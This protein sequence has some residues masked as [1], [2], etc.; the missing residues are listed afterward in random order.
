MIKDDPDEYIR[1]NLDT[2]AVFGF[3]ESTTPAMSVSDD[4]RKRLYQRAWDR[5]NGFAFMLETFSDII[6][7]KEANDT[8]TDFVRAKIRH[9]VKDQRVADLLCPSD[10]YAKRPLATDHYY[11]TYNRSNVN[12]ID[13]KANP[14]QEITERGIRTAAG[15]IDLDIII[16]ATGFDAVTGNYLKIETVGRD[17]V[18]LQDKWAGGPSAFA[19]VA[20][21]GFP[22]L[23][24]IYGPFCP[25]TSQPLVHEW[26]VNWFA[27]LI[28]HARGSGR[29]TVDVDASTE[30]AWVQTCREGAQQTLFAQTDSWIN[31]TNIPG[32]PKASMFYMGGMANYM[33]ELGHIAQSGYKEFRIG[34]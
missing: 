20:I 29:K 15:E 25:F 30:K 19:G 1:W 33:K 31:G 23:F 11:E 34:S 28:A 22:N 2:G 12:L 17:G 21:S 6:V 7:S 26:Q 9:T 13:V 8:A 24:M 5:G 10:Y 4:E 18:R 3:R 16:F 32:K 14:I 27:D